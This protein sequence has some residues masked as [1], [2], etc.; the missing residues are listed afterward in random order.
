MGLRIQ[1]RCQICRRECSELLR[2]GTICTD[3]AQD[4]DEARYQRAKRD[5]IRI[6]VVVLL[7]WLAL[8]AYC[9]S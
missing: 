7:S 9:C 6:V 3:C 8:F 4:P 2:D 1:G 5:L